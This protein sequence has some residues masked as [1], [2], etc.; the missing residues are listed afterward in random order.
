MMTPT[1]GSTLRASSVPFQWTSGTG[2][3]EYWLY[4]GTTPGGLDLFNQAEGTSLSAIVTGL[5]IDS[6]PAYVRLWSLVG[7]VWLFN[8]YSYTATARQAQMIEPG[9]GSRPMHSTAWFQWT[10]G[11][12]VTDSWLYVG[13]APGAS[14]LFNQDEGVKQGVMVTGLPANGSPVHVRLWSRIN[15]MWQFNDYTFATH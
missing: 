2:V 5:P 9:P 12:G 8:D 14:D 4:V 6:S 1:P 15:G 3:T 11:T 10:R 7:G 13:T